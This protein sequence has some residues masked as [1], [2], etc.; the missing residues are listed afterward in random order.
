[1]QGRSRIREAHAAVMR[2]RLDPAQW[3]MWAALA[4]GL[5][6]AA[7]VWAQA[8]TVPEQV[9]PR[10]IPPG[11]GAAPGGDTPGLA[12]GTGVPRTGVPDTGVVAPPLGSTTPVIRPPTTGTM[13]VIPPP[14]SPGGDRTV[15]PK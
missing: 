9:Q 7:P 14:G 15:V 11:A 8:P 10:A 4:V 13:P 1:M 3:W 5:L 6:A 2:R 12:P